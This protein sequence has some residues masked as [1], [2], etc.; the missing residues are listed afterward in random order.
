MN[1]IKSDKDQIISVSSKHNSKLEY[2]LCD[3]VYLS[4]RLKCSV[5]LKHEKGE[6]LIDKCGEV[7]TVSGEEPNRN[8]LPL[9]KKY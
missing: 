9:L 6:Y 2:S 7:V 3:C 4:T 5:N 8:M 1:Y